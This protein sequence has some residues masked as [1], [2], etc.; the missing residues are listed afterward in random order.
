MPYTVTI[1]D[2]EAQLLT[3]LA[4]ALDCG[5]RLQPFAAARFGNIGIPAASDS[6][7]TT[8]PS[9]NWEHAQRLKNLAARVKN[10]PV[11]VPETIFIGFGRVALS[12][13]TGWQTLRNGN[14]ALAVATAEGHISFTVAAGSGIKCFISTEATFP[15]D[16]SKTKN[17]SGTTEN[18]YVR[19]GQTVFA[20]YTGNEPDQLAR[21][22]LV[23]L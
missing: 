19:P 13:N 20:K 1:E 15:N 7:P 14:V 8:N 6:S 21:F 17:G 18:L 5:M 22:G 23:K 3:D 16:E 11:P 2:D 9:L 12:S 10:S 4:G